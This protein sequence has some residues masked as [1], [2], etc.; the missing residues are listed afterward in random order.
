MD[1]IAG[2]SNRAEIFFN[3][4]AA[5]GAPGGWAPVP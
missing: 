2:F 4:T 5:T 1:S 3:S